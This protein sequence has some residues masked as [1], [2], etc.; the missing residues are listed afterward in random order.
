MTSASSFKR[1]D[2]IAID[3]DLKISFPEVVVEA[4]EN[5]IPLTIAVD[6]QVLRERKWW[7]NV[8]IKESTQ[9]FELRYHPLTNVHEIKNIASDDRY[10]FNSRQDAM[11]VLGT[12]RGAYLI[13]QKDLSKNHHYLVQ[14]RL[15]LDISRL[16][17]ALR[18]IASLSPDWRL[19]SAWY[20][21]DIRQQNKRQ[22]GPAIDNEN[23]AISPNWAQTL[24][25]IFQQLTNKPT[26][27]SAK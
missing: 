6:V 17:P 2:S 12:I 25:K 19:E 5:G 7:R 26:Q 9:L 14:M 21:W 27:E 16:P 23:I 10:T 18:Q 1:G 20:R 15:L 13:E 4:L 24:D 22:V 11:A 3:A 8:I